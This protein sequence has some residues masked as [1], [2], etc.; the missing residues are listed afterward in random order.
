M[1]LAARRVLDRPHVDLAEPGGDRSD[2]R[3]GAGRKAAADFEQALVD[4]LAGEIDVR[5]LAEH[6]RDLREAVARQRA[7]IFEARRAGERGLDAEGDLLFDFDRRERRRDGVDL[8][9][10]V[11]DVGHRVD[12]Y[13]RERPCAERA[14]GERGQQRRTIAA[15]S[16]SR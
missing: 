14:R 2:P 9:L 1:P 12:R 8:H 6:R 16:K 11:G 7:G 10:V 15:G 5:P 3:L 4:L 13:A